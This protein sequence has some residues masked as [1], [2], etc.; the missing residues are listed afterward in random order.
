MLF[1]RS[2]DITV[3]EKS[4]SGKLLAK[5]LI[6]K[7]GH[8]FGYDKYDDFGRYLKSEIIVSSKSQ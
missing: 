4:S 3:L 5:Y 6:E 1:T 8:W 2:Q 7:R